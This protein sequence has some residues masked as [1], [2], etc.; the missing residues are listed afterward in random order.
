MEEESL[1]TS[2]PDVVEAE[3]PQD[4][5]TLADQSI[6][7]EQ[8]DLVFVEEA[9]INQTEEENTASHKSVEVEQFEE[10]LWS[11]QPFTC[12]R[13]SLSFATVGWDIPNSSVVTASFMTDSS[14]ANELYS[15][16]VTSLSSTSFSHHH[17]P[18]DVTVVPF[19]QEDKEEQDEVDTQPLNS[20]AESAGN[21][22]K[23]MQ[24]LSQPFQTS[25]SCSV[26]VLNLNSQLEVPEEVLQTDNTR[27][28]A[29]TD[30]LKALQALELP[31]DGEHSGNK[32]DI[33][34][35]DW[36]GDDLS[37]LPEEMCEDVD[38]KVDPELS[39]SEDNNEEVSEQLAEKA[40][41][42]ENSP[43]RVEEAENLEKSDSSEQQ[44][45]DQDRVDSLQPESSVSES[46][47]TSEEP[48]QM[49][50]EDSDQSEQR[51]DQSP[52]MASPNRLTTLEIPEDQIEQRTCDEAK[53]STVAGNPSEQNELPQQTAC[54]SEEP[55]PS[56][57]MNESE[58]AEQLS[59]ET[60]APLENQE[61]ELN[62]MDQQAEMSDQTGDDNFPDN[63]NALEVV[64]NGDKHDDSVVPYI[65]G[66][67]VERDK[68]C[69]LAEQLFKLENIQ[70]SDVVK[71]LD[72]E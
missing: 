64:A 38:E 41:D 1:C 49:H 54:S 47:E 32:E 29:P 45:C 58:M 42:V 44:E 63:G 59:P 18:Q 25:H 33:E 20:A 3:L 31:E 7:G 65:N 68:A 6:N 40:E 24:R 62:H 4:S 35:P 8:E 36:L 46:G 57:K 26:I 67:E 70:R 11:L 66:G 23:M 37:R 22:S 13:S 12:M 34:T 9:E 21:D 28:N 39:E 43:E 27:I 10:T 61:A 17:Q 72:K 2:L 51:M 56:D 16:G 55:G 14:L 19:K 71:H 60:E 48:K 69:Q 30:R 50:A 53:G 52:E 5:Q 15:E